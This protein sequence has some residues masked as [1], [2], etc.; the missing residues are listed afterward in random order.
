V[1]NDVPLGVLTGTP[2]KS[3]SSVSRSRMTSRNDR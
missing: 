2:L 1:V 3:D